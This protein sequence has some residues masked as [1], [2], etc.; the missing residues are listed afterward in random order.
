MTQLS[1]W[2]QNNATVFILLSLSLIYV[3]K[4]ILLKQLSSSKAIYYAVLFPGVL[5]HE[6]S[7]L[8]ACAITL[9]KVNSFK[10]FSTSG[11]YV[12]H[13]TPKI[14]VIGILFIS[15]APLV[16]GLALVYLI[17]NYKLNVIGVSGLTAIN[18]LLNAFYIYVLLAI[19]L[20]MLPSFEDIKNSFY[21]LI[22]I[23]ALSLIFESKIS[24][25]APRLFFIFSFCIILLVVLNAIAAIVNRVR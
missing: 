18:F 5:I 22:I 14:P 2:A 12:R 23:V 3:F 19:V 9:T 16:C 7:H 15:I 10:L 11:G 20:T 6:I 25:F 24:P 21:S 4:E 17:V 13:E 1:H 8:S